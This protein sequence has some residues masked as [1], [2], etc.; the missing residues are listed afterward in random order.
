MTHK[1][2][3]LSHWGND[4]MIADVARVSYGKEAS[5]YTEEQNAKLISYLW[6]HGHTSPFRHPHLQFRV[7]CS[8]VVERQLFKH[9]VGVS[10]NSISGRYVDF[11]DE[12]HLFKEREWRKQS[13]SS[14]QGSEGLTDA[15]KLPTA[16]QNETVEHCI[17]SYE[18]LISL[19]V[20]KEQAR[21]V[22]PMCLMTEFIWTGSLQAFLHMCAL[23]LK[24]DAQQE[25]RE[26]V[27]DMFNL[28]KNLEGNPFE[29][30]LNLM[31]FYDS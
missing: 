31:N 23:R 18:R 3:L 22:L 28:L 27:Q 30:T 26:V 15:Q 5:N 29:H 1:V 24:P 7:K 12:Y 19:G 20:S 10:T 2:E 4:N 21:F 13:T 6:K 8:I 14:K 16:I 9:T 11:S 17:K 25:T